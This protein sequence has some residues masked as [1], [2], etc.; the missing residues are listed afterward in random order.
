MKHF[1]IVA[2]LVVI[3]TVL[4]STALASLPFLPPQASQQA[5]TV[6]WLLKLELRIIAF[7][8]SLIVVFTL[9][10]IVVFR[11]KSG[12][13]EDGPHVHGSTGLEIVW[14][15]IPLIT[16]LFL[17]VI[18]ARSLSEITSAAPDELV[19]EV[20]AQQFAWRFDYPDYG[21]TTAE[22][23]LPSGRQVHLK[24]TSVDVIHSFWIPE[25]RVKQDAVPGMTT[26][27]RITPTEIG[28]YQV[29]CA[30][31]CGTAHYSM[32]APVKIEEPAIF[33]AWVAANI[34]PTQATTE[35]TS[36]EASGGA[37]AA[38]A[39]L[40]ANVAQMQGCQACHSIDGSKLVGP[41]WLGLYGSQVALD[42]GTTVVA[43]EEYLRRSILETNAQI[44]KGYPANVMPSIYQDTLSEEQ[45][46][47]LVEYIKSLAD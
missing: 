6:D 43:D 19:V 15:I 46:N 40:G 1:I 35:T 34:A 20:T 14:T 12:D 47:A 29:R 27:L 42:D 16:V 24:L 23:H 28:D 7:L 3:A 4:V 18:G 8:F 39:E 38:G 9:Y 41:T 31:L 33:E 44:V 10:S 25:L 2:V 26:E 36:S 37:Q 45:I 30:E 22:L 17:G 5:A 32:L 11:R 21:V 13:T